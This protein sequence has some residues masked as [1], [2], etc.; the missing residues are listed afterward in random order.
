M[1]ALLYIIN[2][3][4]EF[5]NNHRLMLP[6]IQ[7]TCLLNMFLSFYIRLFSVFVWITASI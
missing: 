2:P 1:C 5:L 4:Y 6:V 3:K 7:S